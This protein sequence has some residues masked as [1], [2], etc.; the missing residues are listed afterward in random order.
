MTFSTLANFSAFAAYLAG[1]IY[2]LASVRRK[3]V[4]ARGPVVMFAALALVLHALGMQGTLISAEGFRF[5]VFIIPSLLL[6]VINLIVLLSGLRRPLHILFLF[7]FPLAALACLSSLLGESPVTVV[8]TALLIH[9]LLSVAAYGVLTIATLEAFLLAYLNYQLK[10]KHTT[11]T[12]RLLPP[13]QTLE[14]LLFTLIWWG[15][16]L[17]T[18]SILTSWVLVEDLM[19]QHLSHKAVFSIIAWLTY[20]VLLWG[21]HMQGWRGK[22]AIRWALGGFVALMLGYFGSKV[23]LEVILDPPNPPSEPSISQTY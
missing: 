12:V 22:T 11:G 15:Q 3:Q 6:L 9:I 21:H 19:A 23:V 16:I 10:H 18:L 4:P 20:G 13:L 1:F 14:G 7:L 5:G 8:D 2:L 17:L